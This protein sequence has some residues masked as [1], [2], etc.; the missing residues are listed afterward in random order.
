MMAVSIRAFQTADFEVFTDAYLKT[1]GWEIEGATEDERRLSGEAYLAA[2]LAESDWVRVSTV[3]GR[4]AALFC[5]SFAGSEAPAAWA[6]AYLAVMQTATDQLRT[7]PVGRSVLA[8]VGRLH[9]V[10]TQLLTE[11]REK[12]LPPASP[13]VVY[14]IAHPDFRGRGAGKALLAEFEAEC[15]RRGVKAAYLFTDNHC[16]WQGYLRD[17]WEKAGETVWATDDMVT[18]ALVKRYA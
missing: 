8:F 13:E 3:D 17:G 10:N 5:A 4:P 14:F 2:N 6:P 11:M 18:Y 9:A 12:G 7:T 16:S 1:W 15:R